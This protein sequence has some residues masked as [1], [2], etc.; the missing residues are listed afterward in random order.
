MQITHEFSAGNLPT[1]IQTQTTAL[2]ALLV[3]ASK[4]RLGDSDL[5]LDLNLDL[6]EPGEVVVAGLLAG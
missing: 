1:K 2:Q 6:A 3:L 5:E 4:S